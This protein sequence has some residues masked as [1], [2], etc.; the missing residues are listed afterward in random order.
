MPVLLKRITISCKVS[1]SIWFL[2]YFL[3]KCFL[4]LFYL[5]G[6]LSSYAVLSS[7]RINV[8]HDIKTCEPVM[9]FLPAPDTYLMLAHCVDTDGLFLYVCFFFFSYLY[10]SFLFFFF[11]TEI[12]RFLYCNLKTNVQKIFIYSLFSRDFVFFFK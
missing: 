5:L 6:D 1:F 9:N 8:F 10:F 3:I 7:D 4:F 12:T 2:F 11:F